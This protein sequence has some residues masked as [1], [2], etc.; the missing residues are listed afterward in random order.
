MRWSGRDEA[1]RA[2]RGPP[3]GRTLAAD[4]RFADP[5]WQDNPAFFA[6]GQAYLAALQLT[7]DLLAAGQ[8]DAVTD[9][10]ARLAADLMLAGLA[11]TNYFATNP[12]ALKRAFDT[13]GASAARRG[14]GTSSMTWSTTVACPGRWTPGR[15][16]SA[17][18]WPPPRERSCSRTTSWS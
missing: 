15:S 8:G 11:P 2:A 13:G 12:A 9:A 4:K 7:D 10:K 6:I 3:A 18:T 5:A 1:R 14:H 17:G 16:R